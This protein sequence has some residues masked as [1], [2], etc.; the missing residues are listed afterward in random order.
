MMIIENDLKVALQVYALDKN[1]KIYNKGVVYPNNTLTFDGSNYVL[2][3]FLHK[4]SKMGDYAIKSCTDRVIVGQTLAKN[5]ILNSAYFI[6]IDMPEIRLHNLTGCDLHFNGHLTV[7]ARDS[8]T[9]TGRNQDGIQT[10]F[11]LVNNDGIFRDFL[12]K[13]KITDIYF[14]II[15]NRRLPVYTQNYLR[16]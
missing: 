13:H 5:Q 15:S 8:I 4:N 11:L 9:Y 2:L 6:W 7:P 1:N 10:G 12:V 16:W 3:R 14:G